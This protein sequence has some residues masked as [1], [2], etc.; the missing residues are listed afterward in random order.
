MMCNLVW[1]VS[2]YI[3][4]FL[5]TTV[6][7]FLAIVIFIQVERIDYEFDYFYIEKFI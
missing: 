6:T 4:L 5:L 3:L 7:I 1:L 2:D